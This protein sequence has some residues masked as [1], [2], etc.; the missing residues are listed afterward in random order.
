L[1]PNGVGMRGRKPFEAKEAL[2]AGGPNW[3]IDW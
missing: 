1:G 3:T 2:A